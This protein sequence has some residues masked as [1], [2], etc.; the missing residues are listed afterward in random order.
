MLQY[1]ENT[2]MVYSCTVYGTSSTVC[3]V[4]Y[5]TVLQQYIWYSAVYSVQST[6]IL[7]RHSTVYLLLY[8]CKVWM[9]YSMYSTGTV[10]LLYTV[11]TVYSSTVYCCTEYYG[12]KV[13]LLC[14]HYGFVPWLLYLIDFIVI[15][16]VLLRKNLRLSHIIYIAEIPKVLY[17]LSA[18]F[19]YGP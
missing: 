15:A 12:V 14:A 9:E 18:I 19:L 1:M 6:T 16:S 11:S 4:Q 3:S 7:Y 2:I 8:Y 5:C 17:F 13:T 10:Y